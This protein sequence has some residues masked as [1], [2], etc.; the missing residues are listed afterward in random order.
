MLKLV[1]LVGSKCSVAR[2]VVG[3][4]NTCQLEGKDANDFCAKGNREKDR[5]EYRI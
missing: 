1:S 3:N 2:S 5:E 4:R